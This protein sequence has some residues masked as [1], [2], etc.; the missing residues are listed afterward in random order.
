MKSWK[1][2]V[3]GV[4]R[5]TARSTCSSPSTA[6]RTRSPAIRSAMG[7]PSAM[8]VP[9]EVVEQM[10]VD[11]VGS[12]D[13]Q[14]VGGARHLLEAGAGDAFYEVA[15]VRGRGCDIVGADHDQRGGG[16]LRHV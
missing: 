4:V 15:G 11:R 9:F 12:L 6:R 7:M 2:A 5:A 10:V 14:Q 13:V 1:S 8:G 16:D 3:N